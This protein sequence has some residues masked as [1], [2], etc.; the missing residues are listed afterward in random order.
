MVTNLSLHPDLF[1][2]RPFGLQEEFHPWRMM[3]ARLKVEH[4]ILLSTATQTG[5]R[6]LYLVNDT[7]SASGPPS[8]HGLLHIYVASQPPSILIAYTTATH[9]NSQILPA[10]FY[11]EPC[12]IDTWLSTYIFMGK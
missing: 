6:A 11:P 1:S 2:G 4:Y 12:N 8:S 3:A 9:K 5:P 10:Q 7:G